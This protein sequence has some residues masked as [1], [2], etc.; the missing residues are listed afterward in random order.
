MNVSGPARDSI[1]TP[2]NPDVILIHHPSLSPHPYYVSVWTE[3]GE[4]FDLQGMGFWKGWNE[5]ARLKQ[6][7]KQKNGRGGYDDD[8]SPRPSNSSSPPPRQTSSREK[9]NTDD[10]RVSSSPRRSYE[11]CSNLE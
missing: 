4:E 5:D 8:N 3:N 1:S 10:G 6:T 7:K 2:H 11:R 9:S